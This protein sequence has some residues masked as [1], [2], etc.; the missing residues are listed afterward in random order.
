MLSRILYNNQG[1]VLMI[2]GD[3]S[4]DLSGNQYVDVEVPEG[5]YVSRVDLSGDTPVPVF[6]DLPK[7]QVENEIV[8]IKQQL[9]ATQNAL[10]FFLASAFE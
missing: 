3:I 4:T 6:E 5:K 2:W 7:N 8:E 10:D 1:T 9:I